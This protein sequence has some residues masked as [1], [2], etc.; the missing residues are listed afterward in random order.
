MAQSNEQLHCVVLFLKLLRSLL[1]LEE[2]GLKFK[3]YYY[4]YSTQ[5]AMPYNALTCDINE[6]VICL[7]S[8]S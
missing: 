4:C 3:K 1:F 5:L 6:V 2:S 7:V 8:I